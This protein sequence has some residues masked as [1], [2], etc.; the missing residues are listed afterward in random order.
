MQQYIIIALSPPPP[1]VVPTISILVMATAT[2][3]LANVPWRVAEIRF[4][5][6]RVVATH[7][8]FATMQFNGIIRMMRVMVVGNHP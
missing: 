1:W 8:Y 2:I 6:L 7:G 3:L 5:V 4:L